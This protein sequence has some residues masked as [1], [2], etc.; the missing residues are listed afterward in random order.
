[1]LRQMDD[2]LILRNLHVEWKIV[3]KSVFPIDLETQE[4]DV[5]LLGFRFVENPQDWY[6]FYHNPF[7]KA[8]YLAAVYPLG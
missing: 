1:M 2:T 3:S 5:E 6:R 8:P 7:V 4:F